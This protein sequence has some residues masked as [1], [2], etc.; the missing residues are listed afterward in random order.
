ME[1]VSAEGGELVWLLAGFGLEDA[2][3]RNSKMKMEGEKRV[4]WH[5]L[6]QVFTDQLL[7]RFI[8]YSEAR[9]EMT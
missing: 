1:Q 9:S 3:C 2:G 7:E 5:Q 6:P 8:P 4:E